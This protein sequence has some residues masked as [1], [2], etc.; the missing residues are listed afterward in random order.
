MTRLIKMH[1]S[2]EFYG[3]TLLVHQTEEIK[4]RDGKIALIS[5]DTSSTIEKTIRG[6]VSQ[7]IT[8]PYPLSSSVNSEKHLIKI[9]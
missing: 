4:T 8:P 1:L 9:R 3:V 6:F 5:P 2:N 7:L